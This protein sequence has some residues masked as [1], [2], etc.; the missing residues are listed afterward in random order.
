MKALRGGIALLTLVALTGSALAQDPSVNESEFNTT[1]DEPDE[2]YLNESSSSTAADPTLN[3]TDFD[4]SA[5]SPD[6]GY[7]GASGGSSDPTMT[8]SDFDTN[9]PPADEDYLGDP[10]AADEERGAPGPGVALLLLGTAIVALAR[11]RA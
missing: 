7:L 3:E 1:A 10:P 5:P 11:A 8:E 9:V 2:S 4:T 6:E